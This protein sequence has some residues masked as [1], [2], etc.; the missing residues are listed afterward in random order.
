MLVSW[1]ERVFSCL[2]RQATENSYFNTIFFILSWN[3]AWNLEFKK[4]RTA[5]STSVVIF[6]C[7]NSSI[8][9][10]WIQCQGPYSPSLWIRSAGPLQPYDGNSPV[11]I[12][13]LSA[14]TGT[15]FP[16][17]ICFDSNGAIKFSFKIHSMS[18]GNH[19]KVLLQLQ[20]GEGEGLLL[21]FVLC[22]GTGC[23]S[24]GFFLSHFY[25]I[26]L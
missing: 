10:I 12:K 18:T 1:I 6:L 15:R 25:F 24:H 4:L 20:F 26:K 7:W 13:T 5:S 8:W 17:K 14:P 23:S 19:H 22:S 2:Q 16:S 9:A 3:W 11:Q 21:V